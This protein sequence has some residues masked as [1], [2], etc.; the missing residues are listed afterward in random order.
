M[1]KIGEIERAHFLKIVFLNLENQTY[2]EEVILKN[3]LWGIPGSVDISVSLQE[4]R[5]ILNTSKL[6]SGKSSGARCINIL[7]QD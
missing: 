1:E 3:V 4:V 6:E 7:G 2:I 5:A